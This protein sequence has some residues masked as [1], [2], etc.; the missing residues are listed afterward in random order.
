M[1][2]PNDDTPELVLGSRTQ[3]AEDVQQVLS[4]L[5]YEG[6]Q[7]DT[8]TDAEPEPPPAEPAGE[9][10]GEPEN[11]GGEDVD[12]SEP[13]E[14]HAGESAGEGETAEAAEAAKARKK[15]G[16]V[17]LKERN[18]K[19]EQRLAELEKRLA[20]QP[21]GR[22]EEPEATIEAEP[23]PQLDDVDENGEPRY[24]DHD[25]FVRATAK[26]AVREDRRQQSEQRKTVRET[27]AQ[28]T[29][30]A[31]ADAEVKAQADRWN[32]QVEIGRSQ[33]EDYDQ[34][35]AN[36]NSM[37]A[38]IPLVEAMTDSD[39]HGELLYHLATH[40]ETLE[41]LNGE[42]TP[43]GTN[44]DF[45]RKMRRAYELVKDLETT[46]SAAMSG[47][48]SAAS[49]SEETQ[50]TDATRES[51]VPAAPTPATPPTPKPEPVK[52][53]GS[54]S[55]TQRKTLANMTRDEIHNMQVQDPDGFRRLVEG[56][57]S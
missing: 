24:E 51:R 5:G 10:E 37:Q 13:S 30:K 9:P 3:S 54:R 18:Q 46:V 55:G 32:S 26:W 44:Y 31:K 11:E 28:N 45:R 19:L 22:R 20:E 2:Q 7:T 41:K 36:A 49:G 16:S 14:P 25:A 48:P 17:R 35:I 4:D 42:L 40:P 47:K 53:V 21:A 43:D 50:R 12:S 1:I 52:P 27:E 39:L 33:H 34:V 38:A 56:S 23:E 8:Q 15:S 57:S 6:I 29:V